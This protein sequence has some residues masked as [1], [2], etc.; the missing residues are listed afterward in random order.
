MGEGRGKAQQD[1]G[2]WEAGQGPQTHIKELPRAKWVV[3]DLPLLGAP[4]AVHKAV[5]NHAL[6]HARVD[7]ESYVPGRPHLEVDDKAEDK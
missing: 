2:L 7:V 6:T 1:P 5:A 4:G 3:A